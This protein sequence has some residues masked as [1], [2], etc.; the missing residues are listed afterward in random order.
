MKICL[1]QEYLYHL[2]QIEDHGRLIRFLSKWQ[3]IDKLYNEEYSSQLLMYW[4]K[5]IFF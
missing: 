3:I 5:V 2:C 4:R 1:F